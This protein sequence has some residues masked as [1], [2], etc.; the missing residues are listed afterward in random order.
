MK[1]AIGSVVYSQG[2][3]Y[4]SDFLESLKN[5]STQ[6]FS[7]IL[8]NDDIE[9]TIFEKEF[10]FYIMFFGRRMRVYHTRKK[11]AQP[12]KLRIE[13]LKVAK[14][15]DVDLLI[16]CDCDDKCAD[17]RVK[18]NQ[19]GYDTG[20]SFLYNEFRS[21]DGKKIMPVMPSITDTIAQIQECNYLGL[22]NTALIMNK[23]NNDFIESLDEGKTKI[24]DW[25][26]FSRIV[27]TGGKGKKIENTVTYYR[28]YQKNLAG[29]PSY[30]LKE[31]E[32]E[33]EIKKE[34]YEL[35]KKYDSTYAEL[36]E[37]YKNIELNV[38]IGHKVSPVFWWGQLTCKND[39]KSGEVHL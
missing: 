10:S 21:F 16:L 37:K 5:Q 22:A 9:E 1:T 34:H 13:L 24:F 27:L 8:L 15:L 30:S 14:Q 7:I 2:L 25:Y 19:K 32:K 38:C 39:I 29:I 3:A 18:E 23:M 28:I 6:D 4:I 11:F 12:Y 36:M 26:L 17:N 20:L 35:L 33:I 31:L